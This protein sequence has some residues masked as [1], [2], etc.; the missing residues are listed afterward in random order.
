MSYKSLNRSITLEH[1][2]EGQ[3]IEIEEYIE[4]LKFFAKYS[5][6]GIDGIFKN[7]GTYITERRYIP[8]TEKGLHYY[9]F[10]TL[11][12]YFE[13]FRSVNRFGKVKKQYVKITFDKNHNLECEKVEEKK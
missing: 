8:N 9:N 7:K 13:R 1:L 6:L 4:K 10:E 11:I 2:E 3:I 12:K 5:R